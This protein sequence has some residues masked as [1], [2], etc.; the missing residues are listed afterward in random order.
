MLLPLQI[1]YDEITV[2]IL[3][4]TGIATIPVFVRVTSFNDGVTVGVVTAASFRGDG[5]QLTGG[6]LVL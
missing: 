3:T 2:E 5:S 1:S 4:I 6:E